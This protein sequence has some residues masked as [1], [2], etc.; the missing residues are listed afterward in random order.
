MHFVVCLVFREILVW[1]F[2]KTWHMAH[3]KCQ[4]LRQINSGFNIYVGGSHSGGHCV[5]LKTLENIVV[6]PSHS[7]GYVFV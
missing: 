7:P 3:F 6:I 2:Q 5:G 1:I 4:V